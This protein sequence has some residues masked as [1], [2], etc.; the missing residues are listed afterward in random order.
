MQN[1]NLKDSIVRHYI[2]ALLSFSFMIQLVG[3]GAGKDK[4]NVEL[5]TAMMDQQ[6]FKS[7]DWDPKAEDFRSMRVPPE[8]TIPRGFKPYEYSLDPVAAEL[9]LKNPLAGQMD[10]ATLERGRKKFQIY[11]ALCHG[12]S[13]DGNGQIAVSLPWSKPPSFLTDPIKGYKDGRIYH[14]IRDGY[15][16]MGS[17]SRQIL[18]EEDRWAVVNY[19]RTLQK[20]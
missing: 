12:E 8:H 14:A 3:C 2:Y 1:F 13:G 10:P 4:T 5:V 7:Q 16:A 9:N 11:C 6:S 15:G 19:I 17:Y 20:K 18:K